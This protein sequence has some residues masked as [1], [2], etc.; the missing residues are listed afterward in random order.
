MW[1]RKTGRELTVL[2]LLSPLAAAALAI[3]LGSLLEPKQRRSMSAVTVAG[4]GAAY[5]SGGLGA[6]EF[7]FCGVMTYLAH[8]GL[9]DYRF[10]GVAWVLHTTWDVVHHLYGNPLVPFA[11]LSSAGCAI[12]DLMLAGWYFAGAPSVVRATNRRPA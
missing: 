8:R 4:A 9:Q 2:A 1:K 12:C 5:L 11:P 7:P 10:I 3:T 6:W